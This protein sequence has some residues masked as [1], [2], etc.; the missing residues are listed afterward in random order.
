[1]NNAIAE[2]FGDSNNF[3]I[4]SIKSSHNANPLCEEEEKA[5]VEY[6][7]ILKAKFQKEIVRMNDDAYI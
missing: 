1:M 6:I 7:N 5:E 2:K 3:Q 4:K